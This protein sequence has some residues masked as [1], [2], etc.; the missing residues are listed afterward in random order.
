MR[1]LGVI[2]QLLAQARRQE[3]R[4]CILFSDLDHFKD[5]NDSMGHN[6]GDELL[7]GI[8]Q[9][10][11]ANVRE[12]DTVARLGGDEFVVLL[13]QT[14][15]EA[16]MTLADKLLDALQQPMRIGGVA[17]YHPHLSMGVAM[18]PDDG[19]TLELLLR[20]ADTAMY[21]AKTQGRGRVLL[22]HP[23]MSEE[24]TRLFDTHNGLSNALL[25]GELRLFLQ[26]K[27]R[28]GDMALIGAE[29]LVR[30]ERPGVGL[31]LPGDFIKVAEKTGLLATIDQWML[32]QVVAALSDWTQR[33][34]WPSH[35]HIAVN[36][37]ASDLENALWL[38]QVSDLLQA[39]G[40]APGLLQIELTESDLLQPSADMLQRLNSLRA[41]GV[42]LAIDD[43][44]TGYSS[45]SYLKSL[46]VS[47]IKIDQSFVRD[48]LTD[49]N[50]R[51]LIE[52]MV[53][54]AH[55]LGHTVVAEGV[56]T[57]YQAD[58]LAALGCEAGQGYLLSPA[59]TVAE[60]EARF[61]P[62]LSP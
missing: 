6:V 34:A 62:Q 39:H 60:F 4:F 59:V 16:A 42:G 41:L 30:W 14:G 38:P 15:R 2:P 51:T 11:R 21:A 47:V 40:I 13:P 1:S 55:K 12:Q 57:R 18:F 48:M 35:C 5:V 22:Y 20:N 25:N 28:L 46:P 58:L 7:I 56:E 29:A 37:S 43:F 61:L 23:L 32:Q 27:F 31:T 45:L 53:S 19:D 26:P 44:G 36:Q 9:R 54:L 50:D 49:E 10:L 33:G 24:N 3:N 52:A 17:A 8:A